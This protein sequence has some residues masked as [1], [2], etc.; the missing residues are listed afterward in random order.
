MASGPIGSNKALMD[1]MKAAFPRPHVFADLFEEREFRKFRL[2]QALR[3]FGN[4]GFDDGIAGHITVRDPIDTD[5]FWVNPFPESGP[6]HLLN[7]AAF[8]IHSKIHAARPDVICAAHSHSVYAKAFGALG[9]ELDMISQDA[10]AFY[11]DCALYT[12]H[13]R[14]AFQESEG[15]VIAKALGSKKAAILQ[16]FLIP[17]NHGAIVVTNSVEASI[18]YYIQLEL[19]CHIQ[20]LA[21]SAAAARGEQTVKITPEQA[22]KTFGTLS[23]PTPLGWFGGLVKF[24]LLER[25]EGKRFEFRRK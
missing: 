10:C 11:N 8:M 23:N 7:I 1:A 22:Q 21:D 12:E 19:A 13:H 6:R 17:Q 14:I 18:H 4:H 9:R 3:I 2:A 20:L 25:Q 16:I 24:E 5:A 15:D